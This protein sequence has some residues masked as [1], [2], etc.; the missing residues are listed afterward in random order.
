MANFADITNSWVVH[1]L[2]PLCKDSA[3]VFASQLVP[4]LP[5]R[6]THPEFSQSNQSTSPLCLAKIGPPVFD[7]GAPTL[8]FRKRL[9]CRGAAN[10]TLT[11][12]DK[13]RVDSGRHAHDTSWVFP[14]Q[15]GG[16]VFCVTFNISGSSTRRLQQRKT[17]NSQQHMSVHGN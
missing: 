4:H 8:D 13:E 11:S 1:N 14:V 16:S 12:D 6:V 5:H 17:V 15:V 10:D 3:L 2:L 9:D 7:G